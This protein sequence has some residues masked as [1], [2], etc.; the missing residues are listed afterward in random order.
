M[1]LQRLCDYYDRLASDPS[2]NIAAVGFAPQ[3]VGF[4]IV[5]E[6]DGSLHALQDVRDMSG[7]KPVNQLMELPYG[8][9]RSGSKVMPMFLWDKP[10]Y[11]LGWVPP[12]LRDE[13]EGET[14][15]EA[16]K[17]LKKIDRI[18]DCFQAA[19]ELHQDCS[20]ELDS[21][22]LKSVAAF[23]KNWQPG[24]LTN[25]QDEFLQNIGTGSPFFEFARLRVLSMRIKQYAVF[26]LHHSRS[27]KKAI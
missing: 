18:G 26:G 6:K 8:G 11:L 25:A 9:K 23:L 14:E 7:N 2:Q 3:K 24:N 12:E 16:K 10:E 5:I 22:P 20:I 15:A 21:E 19:Q 27:V 17:R 4:E 13:P 1:I